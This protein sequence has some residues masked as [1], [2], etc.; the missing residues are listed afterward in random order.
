MKYSI[1]I[2]EKKK[3]DKKGFIFFKNKIPVTIKNFTKLCLSLG[4][5]RKINYLIYH[6]KYKYINI[7][8]RKKKENR[9]NFFGDVWH[10]DHAFELKPPVYTALLCKEISNKI[11][12]TYFINRNNFFQKLNK[13][14]KNFLLKNYF[15]ISA[16]L[17]FIKNIKKKYIKKKKFF[18]KGASKAKNGYKIDVNPYHYN[19]SGNKKDRNLKKIFQLFKTQYKVNW[20]KNMIICEMPYF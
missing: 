7:L 16:P 15:Q 2:L 8:K 13:K 3:L 17:N 14:N 18:I 1:N 20:E 6:K 5:P 19:F 10:N 4:K 12:A 9:K 11:D